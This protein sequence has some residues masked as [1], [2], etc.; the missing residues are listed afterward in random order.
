MGHDGF[1]TV[2]SAM[3]Q[4]NGPQVSECSAMSLGQP[5]S[6]H[7]GHKRATPT[8]AKARR[9][10]KALKVKVSLA[11]PAK[12]VKKPR[13]KKGTK[14]KGTSDGRRW[15]K[16]TLSRDSK[17]RFLPKES[18]G[19]STNDTEIDYG[20]F[21]NPQ[22]PDFAT[23]LSIVKGGKATKHCNRIRRLKDPDFVP[24]MNAMDNT[25]LVTADDGHYDVLK[26][27]M[28]ADGWST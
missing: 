2:A 24:L 28:Q 27:L 25:G 1:Q 10:K 7:R 14:K 18:N 9:G 11:G 22:E 21:M 6:K 17:G 4:G 19:G 26:V 15:R 12:N 16:C 3:S 23:I 5:K 20:R 8:S 13:K